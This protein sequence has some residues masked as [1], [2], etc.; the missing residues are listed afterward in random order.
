[1]KLE[2][3]AT[4]KMWVEIPRV[5]LERNVMRYSHLCA[6]CGRIGKATGN[7]IMSE[8]VKMRSFSHNLP[9]NLA[10]MST[11]PPSLGFI[12]S[13]RY[14]RDTTE[15]RSDDLPKEIQCNLPWHSHARTMILLTLG[16]PLSRIDPKDHRIRCRNH[17]IQI[18]RRA[19]HARG[20][21]L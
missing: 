16:I 7:S 14:M 20:P 3:V 17:Q 18:L 6:S 13:T 8:V 9:R 1:M 4:H 12:Q 5:K 10:S 2:N 11:A 21:P 15:I 19:I